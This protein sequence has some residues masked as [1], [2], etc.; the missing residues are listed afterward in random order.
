MEYKR[1][2]N[3]VIVRIDKGEEIIAKIKE[4]CEKEQIK[5]G[6]V[7]GVGAVAR[8]K[9]YYFNQQEKRAEEKIVD[10]PCEIASL[11]GNV[12]TK[13][14]EVYLH[15]HVVLGTRNFGSYAGH[16]VEAIVGAT[17]EIIILVFEMQAEREFSEEIGLNLIAFEPAEQETLEQ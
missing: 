8:A 16:L 9:L 14:G 4:V 3:V 5:T 15:I 13:D 2:G 11:N 6:L 7:S 12:T 10:E 17:T 1:E